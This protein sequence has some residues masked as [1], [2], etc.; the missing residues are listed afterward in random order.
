MCGIG[1]ILRWVERHKIK[2]QRRHTEVE[3][4]SISRI[5]FVPFALSVSV[6]HDF[7]G[8]LC[9]WA[10]VYMIGRNHFQIDALG[11]L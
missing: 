5:A 8:I 3:K 11:F 10:S 2:I 9:I 1:C 7:F 4:L 6:C